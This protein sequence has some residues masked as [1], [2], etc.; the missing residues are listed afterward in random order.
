MGR[1]LVSINLIA[2]NFPSNKNKL[3]KAL[4]YCSR[5]TL[6][7]NF[8]KKGLGLI[9]QPHFV[10]DFSKKIFLMLRPNN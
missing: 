6:N 5:D 1:S 4:D 7:F 9:S 2:L 8:S 3:H 10:Y